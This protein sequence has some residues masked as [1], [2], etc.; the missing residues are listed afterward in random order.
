MQLLRTYQRE[1]SGERCKTKGYT[2]I[3]TTKV[4]FPLF[5]NNSMRWGL[6]WNIQAKSLLMTTLQI[7]NT[8]HLNKKNVPKITIITCNFFSDSLAMASIKSQRFYNHQTLFRSIWR[9]K[10]VHHRYSLHSK[11]CSRSWIF[12]QIFSRQTE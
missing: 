2:V 8:A 9:F 11:I 6:K 12:I 5:R 10:F 7:K 4:D 1:G 3:L